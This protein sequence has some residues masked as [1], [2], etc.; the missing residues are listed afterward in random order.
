MH[1]E[2][3]DFIKELRQRHSVKNHLIVKDH[4][5]DSFGSEYIIRVV[6]NSYSSKTCPK[7]LK[8]RRF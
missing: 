4:V 1:M 8:G 7:K 5:E 6:N 3:K 2:V